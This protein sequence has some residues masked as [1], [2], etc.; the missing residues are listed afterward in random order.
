MKRPTKG[1]YQV[2]PGRCER[3]VLQESCHREQQIF[4]KGRQA[5]GRRTQRFLAHPPC[6]FEGRLRQ[7]PQIGLSRF[8]G[9]GAQQR[10]GRQSSWSRGRGQ[11]IACVVVVVVCGRGLGCPVIRRCTHVA[12][13]T[14]ITATMGNGCHGRSVD[15]QLAIGFGQI[16][17]HGFLLGFPA[18]ASPSL[19]L[20]PFGRIG[21]RGD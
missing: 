2:P 20:C 6:G 10:N 3:N 13:I 19:V 7:T 4:G 14:A 18:L 9:G 21:R 12:V 16:Q 5:P 8:G 11:R 1:G 17:S 15:P